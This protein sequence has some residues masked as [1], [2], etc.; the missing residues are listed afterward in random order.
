MPIRSPRPTEFSYGGAVDALSGEGLWA[1]ALALLREVSEVELRR[2]VVIR[3]AAVSVCDK[4]GRWQEALLLLEEDRLL[5]TH[6]S[7]YVSCM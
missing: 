2:N 5:Y 3:G 7:R 6:D 4:A 1:R